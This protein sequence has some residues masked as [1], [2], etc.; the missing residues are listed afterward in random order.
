MRLPVSAVYVKIGS[1][2]SIQVGSITGALRAMR[3]VGDPYGRIFS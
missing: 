2:L 1:F 3:S